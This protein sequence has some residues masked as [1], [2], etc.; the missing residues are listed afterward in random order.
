MSIHDRV[1]AVAYC[2]VV[3]VFSL[4]FLFLAL[5]WEAPSL[6][7]VSWLGQP[8]ALV[9]GILSLLL[10]LASIRLFLLFAA[11]RPSGGTLVYPGE[12][13]EVR[14]SLTAMENLVRK[15]AQSVGGVKEVKSST[16]WAEDKQIAV[17]IQVGVGADVNIP[18][19]SAQLQKTIGD[20]L[21]A[22]VGVTVE[23]V[24]VLVTNIAESSKRG[25][26]E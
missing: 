6:L 22:V 11:R 7:M 15:V 26:V 4:L 23:H 20:H 13:G 25:R 5:G 17:R 9:G 8:S 10:F 12:L 2:V 21:L 3:A 24:H 16:V 18:D 1:L 14:I 19:L